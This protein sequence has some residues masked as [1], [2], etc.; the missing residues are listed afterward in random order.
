[1][2]R[3]FALTMVLVSSAANGAEQVVWQIG[4]SDHSYAEFAIAGKFPE[5]AARF[6]A[7]PIVFEVGRSDPARDWPY[8]QPGPLDAAWA[9]SASANARWSWSTV[10]RLLSVIAMSGR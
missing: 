3:I 2:Y 6:K 5:F 1:M 4:K 7:K 9:P 8:I 10:P